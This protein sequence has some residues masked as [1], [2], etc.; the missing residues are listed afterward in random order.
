M[1]NIENKLQ[2]IEAVNRIVNTAD[3][4]QWDECIACFTEVVK[5]DHDSHK[6]QEPFTVHREKLVL[7]WIEAFQNMRFTWHQVTNHEV[8]IEGNKAICTSK[9][10]GL[11]AGVNEKDAYTTWGNY[12]HELQFTPEGWKVSSVQYTQLYDEGNPDLFIHQ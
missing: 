11:H 4:K 7:S 10:M 3:N 6:S 9:V 8:L 2:I 5:V 12:R 1:N